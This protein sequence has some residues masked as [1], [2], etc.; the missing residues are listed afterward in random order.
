MVYRSVG[1]VE[2]QLNLMRGRAR[3]SCRTLLSAWTAVCLFCGS[4]LAA[5]DLAVSQAQVSI[6]RG[7]KGTVSKSARQSTL[8]RSLTGNNQCPLTVCHSRRVDIFDKLTV[9]ARFKNKEGKR[10]NNYTTLPAWGTKN[11]FDSSP[12]YGVV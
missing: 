9:C 2:G 4:R 6:S 7:L 8:Y 10:K 11:C 1:F 5:L 3:P 12:Y